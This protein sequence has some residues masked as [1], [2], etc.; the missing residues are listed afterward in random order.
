MVTEGL[1]AIVPKETNTAIENTPLYR[2]NLQRVLGINFIAA[3]T[4]KDQNMHPFVK[5]VK[6]PDWKALKLSFG[7][8]WYN[9]RHCLHVR[10]DGLL[11]DERIVLPTQFRQTV[12][13]SLHLTH[14]GSVA[15]LVLCR[16]IWFPH[17]HQTIVQIPQACRQFTE[18]DKS[19]KSVICKQH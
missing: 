6:K 9:K 11:I 19:L 12:L 3:A 4:R 10:D 15:M 1:V 14:P 5:F 17:I 8:Y 7:Q 18:Q 13:D 2:R 16:H